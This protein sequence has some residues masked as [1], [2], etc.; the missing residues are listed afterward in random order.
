MPRTARASKGGICYHVMNRG[1]GPGRVF[2]HRGD[3]G[4]FV[5][6][7][8]QACARTPMRIL[9][10]CVMP[11]HFHFAL[12]PFEDGDLSRWMH[13]LMTTHVRRY[14]KFHGTFGHL[15]AGRYKAPPVQDGAHLLTVVRYIERNPLR[16]GLVEHAEDWPWCSLWTRLTGVGTPALADPPV[17]LPPD[18]L[19]F[20]KTPLTDKELAAVR[21][22]A[23][24][25]RPYGDDPWVLE[26]AAA[27]G[28]E[29]SLRR[30]GRPFARKP[31]E[32]PSP[33]ASSL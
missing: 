25:N 14:H 20:V 8:D 30:R 26:K 3:Y 27:L 22:S 6:L 16:A 29:S 4:A 24:R 11:T 12:R 33:P 10:Y 1:N 2:E 15:W 31:T 13:W 28:L 23:R 17:R 21:L 7:M 18:W 5:D 9:A 32:V 19:D